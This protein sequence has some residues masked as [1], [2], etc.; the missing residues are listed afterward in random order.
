[1]TEFVQ[2]LF[3]GLTLAAM[4]SL[5]AVGW[6]LSWSVARILNLMVG[7]YLVI[8]ALAFAAFHQDDGWP[9]GLAAAAAVGVAMIAGA[10]TDVLLRA[11]R[12]KDV[13]AALIVTLALALMTH[14]VSALVWGRQSVVVAPFVTGPP[15]EVAGGLVTRQV[16]LVIGLAIVVLGCIGLVLRRTR[17]GQ[18]MRASAEDPVGAAW[19]GISAAKMRSVTVLL[20]A[21]V[22]GIAGVALVPL[23]AVDFGSGI[24]IAIKGL[25]A[26]ILGGLGKT[27]GAVVGA[28]VVGIGEAMIAGYLTS[29]RASAVLFVGLIVLLLVAPTGVAAASRTLVHRLVRTA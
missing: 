10:T 6:S 25:I 16:L 2:Y 24:P 20:T 4:Y 23:T 19:C 18:A 17:Y 28:L 1:V 8:A 7:E 3:S 26:A 14:E 15:V 9:F 12:A 22:A 29:E 21:A 11:T 13:Q 27:S 5:I